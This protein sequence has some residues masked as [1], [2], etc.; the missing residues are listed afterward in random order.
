[1]HILQTYTHLAPGIEANMVTQL[2]KYDNEYFLGKYPKGGD[3]GGGGSDDGGGVVAWPKQQ[4]KHKDEARDWN[5]ME[6]SKAQQGATICKVEIQVERFNGSP[7]P[8]ICPEGREQREWRENRK[9]RQDGRFIHVV[10]ISSDFPPVLFV[11]HRAGNEHGA[12]ERGIEAHL[13]WWI[14]IG[15]YTKRL[16]KGHQLVPHK[17]YTKHGRPPA[18]LAYVAC[19]YSDKVKVQRRYRVAVS[20]SHDGKGV[21]G[22]LALGGRMRDAKRNGGWEWVRAGD[23]GW[24]RKGGWTLGVSRGD[25]GGGGGGGGGGV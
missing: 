14:K 3:G 24:M 16:V 5:D 20:Y 4:S 23:W 22:G 25:G 15:V 2:A 1:M 13:L 7:L 9:S 6:R 17:T 8:P 12:A 18:Y 11:R 19:L 10:V 21:V